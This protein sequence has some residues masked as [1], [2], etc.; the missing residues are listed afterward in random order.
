[1]GKAVQW[2]ITNQKPDGD[3]FVGPSSNAHMYSHG[4]AAIALCEAYGLSQDALLREPAQRAIN[5]VVAAQHQGTGGWR[6]EP[7]QPGD[8]SVVGWQVM[9]LKSGEMA[10]LTVPQ[11]SLDLAGKWLSAVEGAGPAIGTFGYAGPGGTPAM[12][13]EGL[14]CRQ[15]LGSR[16]NDASMRGGADYLLKNLPQQGRETSYYWYYG[17]QVMYH[18]QGDYWTAW[19]DH[20]RDT[21]VNTQVKQGH[22]AG[23]WEPADQWEKS[24]GRIFSTS[25]R[26]LM[27]QVYY[28]HLPLYRQLEQ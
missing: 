18:M 4:I 28:R 9:A 11:A 16:R 8:T 13:A 14:L 6:Y 23:T 15:F 17:T 24:G 25:L 7:G 12:T 2:L 19:N 10:G 20:L 21:V 22:M 3:L 27:L 5:F 26:L 1:V